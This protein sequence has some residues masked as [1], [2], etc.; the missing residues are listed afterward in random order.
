MKTIKDLDIIVEPKGDGVAIRV[1]KKRVLELS[2]AAAQFLVTAIYDLQD[3]DDVCL[4]EDEGLISISWSKKEGSAPTLFIKKGDRNVLATKDIDAL[5]QAIGKDREERHEVA[6]QVL[7]EL[8][9]RR[10]GHKTPSVAELLSEEYEYPSP[11]S[12]LPSTAELLTQSDAETK[13][14]QD[15]IDFVESVCTVSDNLRLAC[16]EMLKALR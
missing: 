10:N 7:D 12:F 8:K 11:D 9:S 6:K 5:V 16:Q 14:N 3:A 1:G 13:D 2:G 4:A 15:F